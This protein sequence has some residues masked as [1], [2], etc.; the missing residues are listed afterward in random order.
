MARIPTVPLSEVPRVATPSPVQA[1]TLGRGTELQASPIRTVPMSVQP[2]DAVM[3]DE[4]R[5]N[6]KN[7]G[8][9]AVGQGL[10]QASQLMMHL[11]LRSQEQKNKGILASEE[12]TRADVAA[13]IQK[14]MMQ[15]QDQ[16]ETWA[17]VREESWKSYEKDRE[18]R[19]QKD[20]WG[21]MVI[22]ADSR[23]YQDYRAK[24]DTEYG[25]EEAKATIRKANALMESNAQMKLRAGDYQGFVAAMDAMDLY[26]DQREAKVRAGLEEGM[27]KTANNKLD[28]VRE[29]PPTQAI[30]A[31]K[32]FIAEI[33]AK[34]EKTGK[35]LA[36]EYP[37]GGLSV[38][39]RVNL[40]SIANARVREAER[41]MDTTGRR[42]VSELRLGRATAADVD[43]AL[44]AGEMDVPTARAISPDNALA[45]RDHEDRLAVKDAAAK[46]ALQEEAQQ[47]ESS[48]NRLR[49]QATDRGTVGL[50]DIERQVALGN[51][52]PQ[53]GAQL[54]EELAQASRAEMAMTT[55]D[56]EMIQKKI[57]GGTISKLFGAQPSDG[58]YRDIQNA[59]I[60]AKL[61]KETRL[62]LM[63]D[64]FTLKLADMADLQEEGP[65][66][67]R[68][69]D[70]K[71]SAPERSLRK[72]MIDSYKTLLP[73]LGDTLA[74]DLLFN[75]EGKIRS[76]FDSGKDG[77]R[78]EGEIKAF[79]QDVLLPEVQKAAGYQALKDA[80][81]F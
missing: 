62:H 18:K 21:P 44:K 11:S 76:F 75:Q 79:Q 25:L 32:Q 34:D 29:L 54:Q 71:I 45:V 36:Y 65:K 60:A 8:L 6:A 68:W 15:T 27:Y 57:R 63:E 39:G 61:T 64:L 52:A 4:G 47:R 80:F 81:D 66:D 12:N 31:S 37:R 7:R 22:D 38:G 30:A 49:A 78:T 72:G 3:L 14:T 24:T 2:I 59:I 16:P 35:Y 77:K 5:L 51:I 13:G 50:R 53:Q 56:Y 20:G 23:S 41:Q 26:P 19:R 69:L 43:A 55:G 1:P 48:L 73:A 58:D 10:M 42:L 33:T 70:R 40:E 9:E 28:S 74:G 46:K 17:K 67:G